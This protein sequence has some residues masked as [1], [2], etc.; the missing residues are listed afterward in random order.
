MKRIFNLTFAVCLLLLAA[1]C[2]SKRAVVVERPDIEHPVKRPGVEDNT[3]RPTR[4]QQDKPRYTEHVQA[5]H[6]IKEARKWIGTPY[7]YGGKSRSGTDCSG[8]VMSV[9]LE[10]ADIR[11]PRSSREQ[12]TY[13]RGIDRSSLSPGD[14]VFFSTS[15][16]SKA[17]SHV[18]IYIGD[19]DFIHASTSKGVIIS[20]MGEQYY[21][22]HYHSCGRVDALVEVR[23]DNG[24]R[25]SEPQPQGREPRYEPVDRL[26][27][28][29][30]LRPQPADTLPQGREP[31][32]EPV[33]RLPGRHRLTARPERH[34]PAAQPDS[35]PDSDAEADSI[36]AAVRRAIVF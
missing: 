7:R 24:G 30:E 22:S 21:S 23:A 4:Q 35:V 25:P 10:A 14:L 32:Y 8:F 33:D 19:G 20:S 17:V 6:I 12:Q 11:L 31:A 5:S 1:S 13:C 3:K 28:R 16:R 2:G 9:F 26:P 29:R 27:G 18:G 36:R 15:R 34:A